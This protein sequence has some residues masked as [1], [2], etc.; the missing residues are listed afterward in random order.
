MP[1]SYGF[2]TESLSEPQK[3]VLSII[4]GHQFLPSVL[5]LQAH[6]AMLSFYVGLGS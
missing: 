1:P 3:V 4:A 2:E 5:W 6:E